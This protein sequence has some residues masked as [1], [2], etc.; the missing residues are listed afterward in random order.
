MN[1]NAPPNCSF[2]GGDAHLRAGHGQ[3]DA[4]QPLIAT[5]TAATGN[6]STGDPPLPVLPAGNPVTLAGVTVR[7]DA[8][9]LVDGQPAAGMLSCVGGSF[10]PVGPVSG[11][12]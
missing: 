8:Q 3:A 2:A 12:R 4:L 9:I 10:A 7:G 5:A 11:C 1:G 6:G